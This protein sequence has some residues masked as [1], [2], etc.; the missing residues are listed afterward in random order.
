MVTYYEA[1]F[2]LSVNV[3]LKL[4]GGICCRN[5]FPAKNHRSLLIFYIALFENNGAVDVVVL[6]TH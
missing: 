2:Q 1:G 3:E 4:I 6:H 5:K